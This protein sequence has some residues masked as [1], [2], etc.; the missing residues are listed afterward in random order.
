M[1]PIAEAGDAG[2]SIRIPAAW[3]GCFGFKPSAGVV[4]SVCRPD[5][6]T[7][8]HP[9]CCSGPVS[10]NV[11]DART[12]LARMQGYDDRDP[13]SVPLNLFSRNMI[14]DLKPLR[15]GVTFDFGGLFPI[16]DVVV[17]AVSDAGNQLR[18]S[19]MVVEPANFNFKYSREEYEEWWLRSI[20]VDNALDMEEW[21]KQGY[22]LRKDHADEVPEGFLYWTEKALNSTMHDYRKFHEIRTEILDA[23]LKAFENF[24]VIIAPVSGCQPAKNAKEFGHTQGPEYIAGEKVNPTIGFACTYLENMIGFPACSIPAGYDANGL[25]TGLQIIGKRYEDHKVL[26]LAYEIERLMPWRRIAPSFI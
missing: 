6:W 7:A 11:E 24:D 9:Y 21:K 10:T 19:G 4:P 18:F 13:I 16:E 8:T 12:I 5:A 2:G 15:V 14:R 3:C 17:K 25:P 20:T 22:D 26:A 1:V 23:H